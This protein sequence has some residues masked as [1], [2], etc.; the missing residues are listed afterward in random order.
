MITKEKLEK[1]FLK[2]SREHHINMSILEHIVSEYDLLMSDEDS[3]EKAID[4]LN[5]NTGNK[6]EFLVFNYKKCYANGEEIDRVY[7]EDNGKRFERRYYS[8][9]ISALGYYIRKSNDILGEIPLSPI[10]ASLSNINSYKGMLKL[11]TIA[12]KISRG[13]SLA[14][15]D[16]VLRNIAYLE[17][18]C[19]E[20]E[21]LFSYRIRVVENKIIVLPNTI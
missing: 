13:G 3:T 20:I 1:D 19:G 16:V 17:D 14:V 5:K 15:E 6:N 11:S 2:I 4:L 18:S 9:D 12:N 8:D 10:I 21:D 7:L